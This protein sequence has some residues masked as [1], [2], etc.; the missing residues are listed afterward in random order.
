M[1]NNLDKEEAFHD[2]W[3]ASVE[4]EKIPVRAAF[5]ACTA[6]EN[7]YIMARLGDIR[8]LRLLDIGAGLGESSVYFALQGAQVTAMDISTK[9]LEVT[10]QLAAQHQVQLETLHSP[11]HQLAQADESYDIV[12]CANLLHHVDIT[13]TLSEAARVLKPGGRFVSWDPL[14]HNPVINVYRRLAQEVRTEDEHPLHMRDLALFN[15]QFRKVEYETFWFFSLYIFLKF[16]FFERAPVGERYWKK[17][18]VEHKRLTPLYTRLEKW[19]RV[20]LRYLPFLRRYCWNIVVI[21]EK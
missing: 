18:I 20:V 17:I 7:R 16:Y 21:A 13:A 1:R 6:P 10:R 14:A 12:Y 9:M 11:S 15:A 5:E 3:A 19:D 4:S 2:D 8:G